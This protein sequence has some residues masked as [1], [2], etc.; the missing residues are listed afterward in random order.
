VPALETTASASG[1]FSIVTYPV[2][3]ALVFGEGIDAVITYAELIAGQDRRDVSS[4]IIKAAFGTEVKTLDGR[5]SQVLVVN[6]AAAEAAVKVFR[7]SLNN[8]VAYEH[9]WLDSGMPALTEW[10]LQGSQVTDGAMK[11]AV[12]A[13]TESVLADTAENIEKEDARRSGEIVA[14]AVPDET[15]QTL[16]QLLKGWAGQGHT[17]LRDQLDLAFTSRRWRRLGWWKLFWR[18]DDVSM[19]AFEV[20]ERRWLVEAEKEIIWL[21]GRI[22]Q[23]GFLEGDRPTFEA[24]DVVPSPRKQQTPG[25]SPP[26]PTLRDLVQKSDIDAGEVPPV[27]P[28]QPWP[29]QIPLAR[30][31]LSTTT[32]PPLQALAQRLVLQTLSTTTVTSALS[33]LMYVSISTTSI[34]EAGAIA[35]FGFVYSMRRLQK[36]WE[37][38]RGFWEGEVREEGRKVLKETES[39]VGRITSDGGRPRLDKEAVKERRIAGEAVERVREALRRVQ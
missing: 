5:E 24:V 8:S 6:V 2:H 1:R 12:R 16:N 15:R 23:A 30:L 27:P 17:E 38:A 35:A 3:K 9:G 7:E 20:L 10:L 25:G 4:D 29:M 32:V 34:Y 31:H 18:V 13:L 36:K 26:P 11:P 28:L 39:V 22:G 37:T 33:A 14:A 21:A 19:I